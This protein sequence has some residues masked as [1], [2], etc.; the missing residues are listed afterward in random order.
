MKKNNVPAEYVVFP[1]EGHGFLKK[2]NEMKGYSGVLTFLDK[3]LKTP[4]PV[5][6]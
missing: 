1:D 2:E 5:K 6:Q 4:V 3:H